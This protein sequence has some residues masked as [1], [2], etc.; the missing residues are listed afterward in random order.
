MFPAS[1]GGG[2]TGADGCG[3]SGIGGKA[4]WPLLKGKMDLGFKGR[5]ARASDRMPHHRG[6]DRLAGEMPSRDIALNLRV[7]SSGGRSAGRVSVGVEISAPQDVV[8]I[9]FDTEK[10]RSADEKNLSEHGILSDPLIP[11]NHQI[12]KFGP[13]SPC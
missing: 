9:H 3:T 10:S 8:P 13:D 1:P 4:S 6:P 12:K 5:P 11:R 7:K 2:P